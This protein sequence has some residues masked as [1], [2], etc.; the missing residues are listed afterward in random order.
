MFNKF[1]SL[2]GSKPPAARTLE[3]AR[4]LQT[5][6][7]IQLDDSFSLP[8]DLRGVMFTVD[9]ISTCEYEH[10]RQAVFTLQGENGETR[11]LSIENDSG[12]EQL[13]FSRPIT[14]EQVGQLFD[15]DQ[16]AEVFGEGNGTRLQRQQAPADLA[17]W[18]DD[19]YVEEEDAEPAYLHEN[20]DYRQSAPPAN[21]GE[22]YQAYWLE[23]DQGTHAIEIEVYESG[24]T[25]VSLV[26]LEPLHRIRELWPAGSK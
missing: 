17:D 19:A 8:K 10:S 5:G 15:L 24:E 12:T 2:F 22:S 14:R 3:H 23:N 6:D 18:S 21:S 26:R 25:D 4:D 7:M 11:Y 1:K 20:S 16:F 13:A 9:G